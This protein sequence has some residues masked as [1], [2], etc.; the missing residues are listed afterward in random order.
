MRK[1]LKLAYPLQEKQKIPESY[2]KDELDEIA[3]D[4]SKA[5]LFISSVFTTEYESAVVKGKVSTDSRSKTSKELIDLT[6]LLQKAIY[7]NKYVIHYGI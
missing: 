6:I 3:K 7:E 4:E 5:L 1:I 2:T